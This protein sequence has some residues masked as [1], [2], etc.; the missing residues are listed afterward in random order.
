MAG[1]TGLGVVDPIRELSEIPSAN[2]IHLH[3][4]AHTKLSHMKS[5]LEDLQIILKELRT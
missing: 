3:V 5:L 4:R 2:N 1:S